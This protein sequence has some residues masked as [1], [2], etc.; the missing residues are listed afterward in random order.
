LKN[1][2]GKTEKIKMFPIFG[3]LPRLAIFHTP[4][5]SFPPFLLG[6]TLEGKKGGKVTKGVYNNNKKSFFVL[7]EKKIYTIKS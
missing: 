6:I 2:E 5:V 7:F 3:G 1:G 4:L